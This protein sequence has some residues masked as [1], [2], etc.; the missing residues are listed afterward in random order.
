M[1]EKLEGVI[2]SICAKHNV[3]LYDI[4]VIKTATGKVLCVYITKVGG[5]N[6]T[7]C[8]NVSKELNIY[9]DN[10]ES[11]IEGS[12]TLEVSSPGLER[13][14]KL[15]KHYMTAVNEMVKIT[16]LKEAKKETVMGILSAIQQDYIVVAT[17]K[18]SLNIPF[19]DIK[20]A[21]TVYQRV[22]KESE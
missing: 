22:K 6:I 12:Y 2:K 5:V 1:F 11:L 7:D 13:P 3:G 18:E 10:D 19:H 15:K 4:E 16:Y 20:K 21:N 17:E 9:L 14:L 8:A